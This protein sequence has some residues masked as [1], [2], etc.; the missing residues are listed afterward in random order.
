MEE[1]TTP[2][3]DEGTAVSRERL[4]KEVWTE[5]MLTVALRYKVS[6]SYL[7]RVCTRLNVPRPSRGY[8][9]R[10]AAGQ[11]L[12]QQ[13]LSEAKPGDELIWSRDGYSVY[14]PLPIPKPPQEMKSKR[15]KRSD[16]PQ[17]HALIEGLQTHLNE[18]RESSDGYL[19]PRKHLLADLVISKGI[20]SR[21]L[22]VA[23]EL[24]LLFEERYHHVIFEPQGQNL[25]RYHLE[26]REKGGRDRQYS[27]LWSP[28]RDTIV[29]IGD[30]AIGLTIFEMSEEFELRYLDGKYIKVTELTPQMHKKIAKSYSWTSKRDMPSGR[31]C[32]QAYSPYP[33]TKWCRQWR[34][35]EAGDFPRKLKAIVKELEVEA[36]TIAKLA[37][38]G[39]RQ[40]EVERQ[41]W[42]AKQLE[43]RREEAIKKRIKDE[44]DSREELFHIINA[45]AEVKRIET[46]FA[47]AERQASDLS[48]DKKLII[49]ERLK[50]GREMVGCTDA[51][52]WFE[53]WKVPDER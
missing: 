29:F 51:L 2:A 1:E 7:A 40:A 8:W 25:I 50:L 5:P 28:S 34:E 23:N 39:R 35:K 11:K 27:D 37:E 14:A 48:D 32:V 20:L 22:D 36:A 38:D 24:F 33:R 41:Q 30:V 18:S 9:A 31:L 4:Y 42:E 10:L 53:S 52:Q 26:E 47:D 21:A 6:S 16:L 3:S 13:P 49:L 12:K 43:W 46:F 19:K 45:W 44:K 15:C 17:I